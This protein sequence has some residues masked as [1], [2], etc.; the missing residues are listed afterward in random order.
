[1]ST[2]NETTLKQPIFTK[3]DL[4]TLI[5][6]LLLEQILTVMMGVMDT[7]MVSGVGESAVSSVSLVDSLNILILQILS[8]LATGGAVVCGQYLGRKDNKGA[9]KCAAQLYFVQVGSGY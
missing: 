8:A 9:K 4:V 2:T 3:K 5:G 6:P 1:M 7:F